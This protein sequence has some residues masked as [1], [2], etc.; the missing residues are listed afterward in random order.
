M[1]RVKIAAC[2]LVIIVIYS[3]TSLF[4]LRFYNGQLR[5]R[6]ES[7]QAAYESG[8]KSK[9]LD[10]SYE[11]N[12][13]WHEYEKAVTMLVH[14]DSLED[15]NSSVARITPFISN[16]NSELM[17]EMQSIYNRLDQIYEEESP[18]WYNIL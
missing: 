1:R 13:Y 11:L 17:A 4:I 16:D 12:S 2:L 3:V 9:A 6:L 14:D 15:V 10:L 8:D 7:I 5:G 18:M